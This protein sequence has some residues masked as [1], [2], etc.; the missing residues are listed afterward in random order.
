MRRI[1]FANVLKASK[2]LKE[3]HRGCP[4]S[5]GKAGPSG[6]GRSWGPVMPHRLFTC[7]P[8]TCWTP[9]EVPSRGHRQGQGGACLPVLCWDSGTAFGLASHVVSLIWVFFAAAPYALPQPPHQQLVAYCFFKK[10]VDFNAVN[11]S[12][13]A[14]NRLLVS[15]ETL[16]LSP[17]V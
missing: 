15:R 17:R 11:L 13:R 8:R 3:P 14:K 6:L 7:L 1:Q 2:L 5:R 16:L 10:K 9:A 4:V 12:C